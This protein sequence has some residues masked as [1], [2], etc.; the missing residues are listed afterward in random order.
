M[1]ACSLLISAEPEGRGPN[2]TARRV[3]AK[4]SA[5]LNSPASMVRQIPKSNA[6]T[7]TAL[8]Q[9]IRAT[10]N[11]GNNAPPA[12]RAH[13]TIPGVLSSNYCRARRECGSRVRNCNCCIIAI[14]GLWGAGYDFDRRDI[15]PRTSSPRLATGTD[16]L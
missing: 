2:E 3:N 16:S 10:P 6:S 13:E 11:S 12:A 1:Y 7:D 4:A 15:A 14:E 5:P 9:I 8:L